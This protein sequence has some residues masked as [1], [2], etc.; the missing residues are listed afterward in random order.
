M[1][2]HQKAHFTAKAVTHP[3]GSLVL[4]RTT[5]ARSHCADG[6]AQRSTEETVR[7]LLG[8]QNSPRTQIKTCKLAV[9]SVKVWY[10]FWEQLRATVTN[11]W[12][13]FC[14]NLSVGV[15]PFLFTSM[16]HSLKI[17][18]SCNF[19]LCWIS[20]FSSHKTGSIQLDIEKSTETFWGPRATYRTKQEFNVWIVDSDCQG[21][22]RLLVV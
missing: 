3:W 18:H 10:M 7:Y 1:A 14:D 8:G 12:G 6:M 15:A 9:L 21:E 22:M 19:D 5:A 11:P 20:E 17:S 4:P 16:E 13:C 2:F